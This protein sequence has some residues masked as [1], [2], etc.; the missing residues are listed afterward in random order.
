MHTQFFPLFQYCSCQCISLGWLPLCNMCLLKEV[1][2]LALWKVI[3]Q[4]KMRQLTLQNGPS[5][6]IG[7]KIIEWKY[8]LL[9]RLLQVASLGL[10]WQHSKNIVITLSEASVILFTHCSC[11][12]FINP[13]SQYCKS[14][15]FLWFVSLSRLLCSGQINFIYWSQSK[16]M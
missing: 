9:H 6:S 1:R 12:H 2:Q 10:I 11:W 8:I 4:S 3:F 15:L 7:T 16:P 13:V 5:D 14:N